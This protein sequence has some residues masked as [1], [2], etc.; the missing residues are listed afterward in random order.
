MSAKSFVPVRRSRQ[1]AWG[2]PPEVFEDR[3]LL[4]PQLVSAAQPAGIPVTANG[5]SI[6]ASLSDDGRYAVYV[7]VATNVKTGIT[8]VNA[9]QDVF[10]YDSLNK[11]TTLVSHQNGAL[12]TAGN[13][14]SGSAV[15][16]GNGRYIAFTND[17][18]NLIAGQ[19]D[20]NAD[21]DLFLYDRSNGSIVLVSRSAGSA[22]TTGNN[23]VRSMAISDDGRF[24]VF[25]SEATNLVSGQVDVNG[26][27]DVFLWDRNTGTT[28]LLSH[29]NGSET[30]AA[31][32]VS[33]EVVSID[34]SG[35]KVV[36]SSIGT[37]L[38]GG[39]SD[40]NGGL[41]VFVNSTS[42]NGNTLVSR[43]SSS[44]TTTANGPSQGGKISGD[45]KWVVYASQGTNV[46]TGVTDNNGGLDVFLF[47]FQ[48]V[49]NRLVSRN[50]LIS[51]QTGNDDASTQLAIDAS[52]SKIVY[53]SKATDVVSGQVD[54]A[55]SLD[56][57]YYDRGSGTNGL[58]SSSSSN[59]STA[60]SGASSNPSISDDGKFIVYESL[61]S[62]LVSGQGGTAGV[63]NIF[64][65]DTGV[66]SNRL[67]S[68][69]TTGTNIGGNGNSAIPT[70][71]GSGNRTEWT[72]SAT[73]LVGND[74]NGFSDVFLDRSPSLDMI[75]V[76]RGA[77]F[78][79]DLDGNQIYNGSDIKFNFGNATDIPI[80]GDWDGDGY[81]N[82]GVF[83]N[84]LFYL[85]LNGNRIW[86]SVGGGD[87]LAGFGTAGDIPIIGDWDGDGRDDIGV[88]RGK[89]WYLD[90]NGN[91]SW[92]GTGGGDT[93][94]NYGN[95]LDKP[96][97]GDWN[98]DGKDD[99][100]VFRNTG[101]FLLDRNGNRFWDGNIIDA[102]F[103]FGIST[104]LPVSGDWNQDG[105]DEIG[106]VRGNRWYLDQNGNRKWDGSPADLTF[107]F[108]NSTDIPL[109]GHWAPKGF[110]A[111]SSLAPLSGG[112]ISA[113]SGLEIGNFASDTVPLETL[114]D[115]SL[116]GKVRKASGTSIQ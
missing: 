4:S 59:S 3:T 83:R 61:G 23:G 101:Y 52:G 102:Y 74:S 56:L 6:G 113:P 46:V 81:D 108:G 58:V 82:I 60:A 12:T 30:T 29:A 53:A 50:Q 72:T 94:F 116:S 32:A 110:I 31:N 9:D 57:F 114:L 19:T 105:I 84:G 48:T 5:D 111:A 86:D 14:K 51:S 25:T 93:V 38:I 24:V 54:T 80:V 26:G 33:D 21:M 55:N 98:G 64:R 78:Y 37:N 15:I 66:A 20:T 71:S 10:V 96:V 87:A 22:I 77:D 2:L 103:S 7:T 75:G 49:T 45:G 85:D 109:V 70:I 106:V 112:P 40:T 44:S 99:I 13:G 92:N 8:D 90:L 65:F 67:L 104:D 73:N 76:N 91:R 62:N 16:S 79:Q 42:G 18:T 35:A 47:E 34:Q 89:V 36:F 95:P 11:T 115:A 27:L 43:S 107:V 28:K 88:K 39:Q 68:Y 1:L 63:K 97:I 100:G 41:D 17:S 69:A